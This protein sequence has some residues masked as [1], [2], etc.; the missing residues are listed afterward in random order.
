MNASD[1]KLLLEQSRLV[2]EANA[3][4]R[5]RQGASPQ[6]IAAEIVAAV[7]RWNLSRGNHD[8]QLIERYAR[9]EVDLAEVAKHF[10][11]DP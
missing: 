1:L 8:A 7:N 11:S 10:K 5:G 4:S 2:A 9:G 3:I 6:E